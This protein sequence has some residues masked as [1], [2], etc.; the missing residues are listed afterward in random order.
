[1]CGIAG[2][3]S[4]GKK[5]KED[6]CKAMISS[7][8][9]R[10]PDCGKVWVDQVLG[11]ALGH[12][13]LAVQDLSPEGYQPM[14]SISERYKIVFNGEI[15]NFLILQQELR[16]LGYPF[17]G[18]SDT[19]VLLA[20]IEEWGV[21]AALR[22][23]VGMF[24]FALWDRADRKLILARDRLGEKPLY[25]GWQGDAFL[26]A[27]ELSALKKHPDWK[28]ELDRGALS[29]YMRHSYVP[30]PYSIYNGILKLVPGSILTL[31]FGTKPGQMPE[32]ETYW[33]VKDVAE[34]GQSCLFSGSDVEAVD[35]LE[36][37]LQETIKEKM[38]SDVPIGAFLS[39]GIDSSA[40]VAIMQSVSTRPIKSFS[41][42]FYDESYN[43]AQHAK[44]VAGVLGTEHTELYVTSNDA[45]NVI[46][47]LPSLYSEPFADSS[48]IPTY[49]VSA[50]T[51]ENVTVALSGDGG[52]ELFAGYNR[53]TIGQSLWN[54]LSMLPV[55]ARAIV[56]RAITGVSVERWNS[57]GS[58]LGALM[59]QVR[60]RTGDKMHKLAGVLAVRSPEDMYR[61][62]VTHWEPGTV[63]LDGYEPLTALTNKEYHAELKSFVQQMQYLD[64]ISYLPDDILVKVDRAAMGVSLETRVPFLDHRV[65]E[66]A[67][68]LPMAMKIRN[69]SS[70]WLLRQM[71]YKYVPERLVERPKMGFGVPIDSWLRNDMRD[72]A[73]ALLEKNKMQQVGL[74]NTSLVHHKWSEHLAGKRNWQHLLWNVLMFQAWLES[75]G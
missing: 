9:H 16:K 39:G 65:V 20:A 41:I 10:G 23:F 26:F 7:L 66:F 71:L 46:P 28:G 2:F 59:P 55:P 67:W 63:V 74:F 54:K 53:Y 42:G 34:S 64:T 47:K 11:V 5:V 61:N 12:R 72:W 45:L 70:K 35:S 21:K 56:S 14:G 50:M 51:K 49:L 22:R 73:E 31:P 44:A 52:D 36:K 40:V 8:L 60:E 18:H 75:N 43:E 68:R 17:R 33:S 25:Y 29:L 13:R 3:I 1:M 48:Q 6:V 37:L 15:Y 69:G 38:I 32:P 19:E 58:W 30:T 24:A 4:Y 62:L 57:I 27:S